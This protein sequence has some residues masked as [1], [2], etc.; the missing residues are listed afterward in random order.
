MESIVSVSVPATPL[1]V[2]VQALK[3]I[4]AVFVFFSTPE[5]QKSAA[6][7]R[8]AGTQVQTFFKD[9]LKW[10]EEQTKK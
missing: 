10:V 3:T 6:D 5:G 4:E 7:W 2:A 1:D 8:T 9:A